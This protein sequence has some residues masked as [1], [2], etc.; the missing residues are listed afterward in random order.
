M[1]GADLLFA[2]GV[3]ALLERSAPVRT[4]AVTS[5]AELTRRVR[6]A[7]FDAILWSVRHVDTDIVDQVAAIRELAGVA[8]CLLADTVDTIALRRAY[9]S[10]ADGL[11]VI[12]RRRSVDARD[13]LRTLLQL[14]AGRVVLSPTVLE[15]LV[16]DSVSA[17]DDPL[18]KL[19][20]AE[21]AVLELVAMGLRNPEIARRLERSQKLVEKHIGRTFAKL[22][23]DANDPRFDRRV[24]AV[25]LFLVARS[26]RSA[27]PGDVGLARPLRTAG[28]IVP[29]SLPPPAEALGSELNGA[30]TPS[31][32]VVAAGDLAR[33]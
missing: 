32:R 7:D 9:L 25:R 2:H 12:L 27:H 31:G 28:D 29:G 26:H 23:L 8:V 6:A 1:F 33:V 18:A 10:R 16:S 14:V 4:E 19:T 5:L 13:V 17:A 20:G 30:A 21:L 24:M 11:A 22:G 15:Q 3:G